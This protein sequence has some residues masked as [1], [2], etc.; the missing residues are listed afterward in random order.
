MLDVKGKNLSQP[1][2]TDAA[3]YARLPPLLKKQCDELIA[4]GKIIIEDGDRA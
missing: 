4:L 1:Y 2:V 3:T